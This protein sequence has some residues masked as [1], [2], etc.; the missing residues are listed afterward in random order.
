MEPVRFDKWM[1]A[2]DWSAAK[3]ALMLG[4]SRATI[5]GWIKGDFMPS[6]N[7]LRRLCLLSEGVIQISSFPPY[8]KA[9][10]ASKVGNV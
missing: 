9:S 8:P 4:V 6:G 10:K 2:N 3:L 5:Y 1:E 7:H